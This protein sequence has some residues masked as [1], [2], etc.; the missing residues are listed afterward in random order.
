MP[1]K[2]HL[3]GVK[4]AK[5]VTLAHTKIRFV[6]LKS[7]VFLC[8]FCLSSSLGAIQISIT[9]IDVNNQKYA[10]TLSEIEP[11]DDRVYTIVSDAGSAEIVFSDG[12]T[13][14]I[15]PSGESNV[16]ATYRYGIGGVDGTIINIYPVIQVSLPV[17]IP[18][19]DFVDGT[20]MEDV[21][22]SLI[23]LARIE[24]EF[25]RAGLL[26]NGSQARAVPEPAIFAL[27]GLSLAGLGYRRYKATDNYIRETLINY[28]IL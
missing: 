2:S 27:I 3:G 16:V 8:F 7:M 12:I 11:V 22:F 13:G 25:S 6:A 10:I 17:L 5:R 4:D 19:S 21:S 28:P 14:A 20:N 26:V 1:M 15:P 24:F 23:G 18:F 9:P